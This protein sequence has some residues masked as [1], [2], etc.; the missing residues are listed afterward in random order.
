MQTYRDT[1]IKAICNAEIFLTALVSPDGGLSP[2]VVEQTKIL[3]K[4]VQ[5]NTQERRKKIL[6][7]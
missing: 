7:R 2:A 4:M 3:G 6:L 5:L 1:G